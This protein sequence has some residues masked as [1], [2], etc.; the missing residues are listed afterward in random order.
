MTGLPAAVLLAALA[1][2]G[3]PPASDVGSLIVH[4]GTAQPR[5]SGLSI[6]A[7]THDVRARLHPS[8]SRYLRLL[9][10]REE[11]G[12]PLLV[13]RR[14]ARLYAVT[15]P[16]GPADMEHAAPAARPAPVRAYY[17]LVPL[18]RK[19]RCLIF[20]AKDRPGEPGA[21]WTALE[22][23]LASVRFRSSR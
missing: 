5:G 1:A 11:E 7:G 15:E 20:S 4:A 13:D 6:D 22:S 12:K 16:A 21:A 23:F 3:P 14:K 19:G 8:M 17:V 10:A 2:A 9:K 18:D